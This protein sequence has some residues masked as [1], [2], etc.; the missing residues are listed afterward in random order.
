MEDW[1]IVKTTSDP[2]KSPEQ[3]VPR[4]VGRVYKHYK[5]A[6]ETF[7]V[8]SVLEIMEDN[9]VKTISG[10]IY[11]L[12]Q[13]SRQYEE[14]LNRDKEQPAPEP[15]AKAETPEIKSS[16]FKKLIYWIKGHKSK[17]AICQRCGQII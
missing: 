7:I 10:N 12:G 14:W 13:P 5:F 3:A 6:D 16:F 17:D 15:I 4:L 2:Y 8:T 9:L 11:E 1:S